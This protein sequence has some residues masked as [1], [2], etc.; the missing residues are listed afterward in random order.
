MD[1]YLP[2]RHGWH[3][4][5]EEAPVVAE[6]VPAGQKLCT[7]MPTVLTKYPALAVWHMLT[8][9]APAEG[10]YLPTAQLRHTSTVEA[11]V[12]PEYLPAAQAWQG[13]PAEGLKNP[14]AQGV[15]APMEVKPA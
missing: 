4:V 9:V 1:E 15:Q 14:L 10:P 6:Y 5:T 3:T 8:L 12:V 7:G 13:W 11:P 2:V